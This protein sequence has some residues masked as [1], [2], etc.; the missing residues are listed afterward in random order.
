MAIAGPEPRYK[1][2]ADLLQLRIEHQDEGYEPGALLPSEASLSE[3]YEVSLNVIGN[4]VRQLRADGYLTTQT[5]TR[6]RIR[7]LPRITRDA[8]KRFRIR[9]QGEARG[10]YDAEMTSLGLES[11]VDQ[12][13]VHPAE[14]PEDIADLIGTRDAITRSRKMYARKA[15]NPEVYP[16]QL[17]DSWLPRDITR[18]SPIEQIDTGPGGTYSR[19]ADLGHPVSE[20]S[21]RITVRRATSDEVTF[22]QI[23]PA[24]PIYFIR[25]TAAEAGG[26]IIEVT[27]TITPVHQFDLLY[28]WPARNWR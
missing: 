14:A 26:R 16:V 20:F 6:P 1:Q 2:V 7:P 3:E 17:A 5:G 12:T 9:E 23:D 11:V 8:E 22:L 27:D 19:L 10:A 18:G 24:Q 21:E 13:E 28:R 4:A 25:R 15:G